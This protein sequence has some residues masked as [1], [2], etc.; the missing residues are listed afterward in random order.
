MRKP[1]VLICL[2]VASLAALGLAVSCFTT[3]PIGGLPSGRPV[4]GGIDPSVFP[5]G[6]MWGAASSSHQVEGN[7][8]ASDWWQWELAGRVKSGQPSGLATDH[9]RRCEEDFDRLAEL[10]LDTYRF[11]L[12]WARLFPRADMTEPDPDAV[13]HYD[14]VFEALARRGLHPMVTLHHFAM[15]Q[16]LT[17]Q[18][19][20]GSGAAIDDFR[21]FAE[22]AATRWGRY[23]DWWITINEPEV[24]ALH[25][26]FRGVFPPGKTDLLLSLRVLANL[27]KAHAAAYQA[28]KQHDTADADGDGRP[29]NVG[30]A[31]LIVPVEPYSP[32]NP[33]EQ[34][35]ATALHT[36]A[37]GFWF[38]A[39]QSGIIDLRFPF[40]PEL[41]ED[42]PL[43]HGTLDFV[44]INYYSRQLIHVDLATGVTIDVYPNVLRSS[45]G[46]EVYPKGL[47]DSLAYVAQFGHPL[48]VT[49]NGIADESDKLR[50]DYIRTHLAEVARFIRTH[51]QTP[52]LGYV[53]W[54]LTDNYEW[55]NGFDPRFGL[56]AVD[57]GTQ[58]RTKRPSADQFA[59]MIA[60]IRAAH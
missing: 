22:F 17:E 10:G 29:A 3:D 28:I 21:R 53:Y 33:V 5:R 9:W 39:E 38:L 35:I 18:D 52:M 12:S 44:G 19:R 37:N 55:E 58:Q 20:W 34:A 46:I 27:M 31:Q 24:F 30:I 56:Y 47:Y 4:L 60:A 43:F 40:G 49:E 1:L 26:W 42:Y 23:V 6:F 15:P 36:F 14:A 51:P 57:Y 50:A 48:I 13:A 7:D 16:W 45:L 59:A 2:A 54:A 32:W 11:S 8:T 25:G 41:V